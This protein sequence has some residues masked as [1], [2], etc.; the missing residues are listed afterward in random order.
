M[1]STVLVGSS[2]ADNPHKDHVKVTV[3]ACGSRHTVRFAHNKVTVCAD[4]RVIPHTDHKYFRLEWDYDEVSFIPMFDESVD[5]FS[6][7]EPRDGV[8]GSAE[9]DLDGEYERVSIRPGGIKMEGLS[10]GTYLVV[11]RVY[12]DYSK[13]KITC[14]GKTKITIK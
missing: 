13:R 14:M 6:Q 1:V 3:R 4:V 12:G 10:G 5:Q 7:P 11:A 8:L 2:S 9:E